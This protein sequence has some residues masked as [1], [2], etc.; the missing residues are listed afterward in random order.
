[1]ERHHTRRFVRHDGVLDPAKVISTSVGAEL[2]FRAGYAVVRED[3][4]IRTKAGKHLRIGAARRGE[5]YIS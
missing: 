1:M 2:R 3:G 4:R 5:L